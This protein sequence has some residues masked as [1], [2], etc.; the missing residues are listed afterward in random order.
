MEGVLQMENRAALR[1]NV[2]V[3]TNDKAF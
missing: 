2:H 1:E 3:K